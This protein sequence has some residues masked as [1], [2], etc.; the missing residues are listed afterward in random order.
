MANEVPALY[1]HG[2]DDQ[3][4]PFEYAEKLSDWTG[5]EL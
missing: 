3:T 5:V 2:T 4:V 1:V